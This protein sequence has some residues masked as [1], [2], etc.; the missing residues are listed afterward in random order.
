MS[1]R[2]DPIYCQGCGRKLII[3]G[4]SVKFDSYTGES[5]SNEI[6]VC[7]APK[8]FLGILNPNYKMHDLYVRKSFGWYWNNRD[9]GEDTSGMV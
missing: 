9:S 7:P 3:K 4:G 2:K 1:E 6:R 8:S 5:T